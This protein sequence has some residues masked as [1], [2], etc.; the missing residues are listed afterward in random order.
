LNAFIVDIPDGTS[1][2]D[3]TA[4]LVLAC[5]ISIDETDG[6]GF[7]EKWPPEIHPQF[8]SLD[9]DSGIRWSWADLK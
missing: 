4:K 1:L 9:A 8:D 2:E 7:Q 6:L 3:V 5:G